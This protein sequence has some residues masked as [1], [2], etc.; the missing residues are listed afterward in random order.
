MDCGGYQACKG[1]TIDISCMSEGCDLACGFNGCEDA[2]ITIFDVIGVM[3]DGAEACKNS[4]IQVTANSNQFEIACGSSGCQN[5]VINV[6]I[7]NPKVTSI[8]GVTC[9]ARDACKG[10]RLSIKSLHKIKMENL[11]CGGTGSCVDTTIRLINVEID[12]QIWYAF[13]MFHSFR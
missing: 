7:H 10:M 8:L 6:E 11:I 4:L 3:C 9:G 13:F 2:R 12:N 1:A 5:A